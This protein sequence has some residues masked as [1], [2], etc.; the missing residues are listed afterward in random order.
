MYQIQEQSLRP[1][2]TAHLAQTMSLL[3]LSNLDLRQRIFEELTANPALELVDERVCPTCQ[4][5]LPKTLFCPRCSFSEGGERPIVFLSPRE[6]IRTGHQPPHDGHPMEQ[7]L[8]APED[9][10]LNVLA[11]LAGDLEPDDR[12]LAAY[13][14]ASLDE[15]GF[16]QDPPAYIA[17]ATR[18]SLG[19]I[20]RVLHL[21]SHADPP[22]LG[23]SGPRE[24]LLVQLDLISENGVDIHLA[25]VMLEEW[26]KELGNGEFDSIAKAFK[27]SVPQVKR[28]AT[29]IQSKLNPYPARLWW[30]SGRGVEP[31]DP[32]VF[33]TPDIMISRNEIAP[34]GPLVVEI[35]ASV[36]GWL[37]VNPAF[38]KALE[39]KDGDGS[40]AWKEHIERAA[41]FVKCMQQR[42]HTMRKLMEILAI[43]Q[44]AFI[45]KGDRYLRAMTRAE[46]AEEIG[47]HESTV[48]RA[49]SH[50]SAGLPDGRI[51]PLARFFDRSLSIRDRIKEIVRDE[52]APLT[53]EQ[54]VVIL[55]RQGVHVAR[56]TVAKY[57]AI[58][59]ILPGRLRHRRHAAT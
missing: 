45:L 17:R 13:I 12:P 53:D 24:A 8:A 58:E 14:L 25:R 49:V 10:A 20:E 55:R 46:I 43:R 36:G 2:T 35:F 44:R 41:L 47:V 11:Q 1:L 21:I 37:R 28:I 9:L 29:F 50:K 33:H 16:L 59:G 51:I 40:E 30:G 26:F 19:Q 22:G 52:G 3:A 23:T 42:N 5:R 18:A 34:E 27:V 56:R 38:R 39:P 6:S 54:I 32:N 15:D 31:G 57:R 7:D 48:S 4:R